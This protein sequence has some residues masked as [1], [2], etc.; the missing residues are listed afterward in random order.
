M[1][2]FADTYMRRLY[3]SLLETGNTLRPSCFSAAAP[4]LMP[5]MTMVQHRS[6]TPLIGVNAT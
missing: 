3:T 1:I 6:I 2:F 4:R 5:V